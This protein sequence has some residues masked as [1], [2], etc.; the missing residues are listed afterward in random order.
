M[1][2]ATM[3]LD[4]IVLSRISNPEN[5]IITSA[6]NQAM[7]REPR[8][9]GKTRKAVARHIPRVVVADTIEV[10]NSNLSKFYQRKFLSRV[11]SEDISDLTEL[12]AEMMD[13]FMED[14]EDLREWLGDGLPALNGR[15]PI[16]LMATLYGRKALREIL[17]RMRY[18][19]FS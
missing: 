7:F 8:I 4:D 9:T 5:V 13:V 19:D 3:T 6:L 12:W 10:N 14:E 17:N 11:Q 15:A 16:E 18:G 1:S 2:N